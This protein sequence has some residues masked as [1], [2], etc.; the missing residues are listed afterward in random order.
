MPSSKHYDKIKGD[1]LD[2]TNRKIL[3]YDLIA[4]IKQ[5][6]WLQ[7]TEAIEITPELLIKYDV[8]NTIV[9]LVKTHGKDLYTWDNYTRLHTF[10]SIGLSETMINIIKHFGIN[11]KNPEDIEMRIYHAWLLWRSLE[12]EKNNMIIEL[13]GRKIS[14]SEYAET[15]DNEIAD[16][17]EALRKTS[18]PRVYTSIEPVFFLFDDQSECI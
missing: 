16:L 1:I 14:D 7:S 18:I 17:Y 11:F 9:S 5:F 8:V 3:F 2:L 10:E 13:I 6:K 12:K 15:I 4:K